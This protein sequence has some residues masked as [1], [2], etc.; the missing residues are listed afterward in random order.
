MSQDGNRTNTIDNCYATGAVTGNSLGI[1]GFVGLVSGAVAISDSFAAGNVTGSQG[2][3]VGLISGTGATFTNNYYLER[4]GQ[5]SPVVSG[6]SS[7]TQAQLSDAEFALY[8]N[9][10]TPWDFTN[11]W[12][13]DGLPEFRM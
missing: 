8:A 6:V 11:I 5:P 10:G 2:W 12:E 1:G 4:T 13:M 7:A 3:F 9:G